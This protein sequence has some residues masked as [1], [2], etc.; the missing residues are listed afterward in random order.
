MI[1]A[2][3]NKT[4]FFTLVELLVVIAIIALLAGLLMPG[5]H[6]ARTKARAIHCRGNLHNIATGF[7]MYLDDAN[8]IMPTV[9]QLPSAG[10]V[11]APGIAEVLKPYLDNSAVFNCP[12][13]SVGY[14][15]SEGS[16]YEY[17]A[18]LC[19]RRV[20][21]T[22]LSRRLGYENVPVMYDYE[23]FHGDPGKPGAA[24]YLFADGHV[25][26]MN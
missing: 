26:D 5:L 22:F 24:N 21:D 12:A 6:M 13:D 2:Y 14:Y 15:E 25:G 9:A 18:N 1:Y 19:D 17:N 16:S 3:N 23:P 4:T 20:E 10:L 7:R 8:D 11:D